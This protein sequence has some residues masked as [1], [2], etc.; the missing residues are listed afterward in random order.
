[1]GANLADH[2]G[3]DLPSGWRGRGDGGPI[4][5]SIA[6]FRSAAEPGTDAPD[7]MFWV[8]DPDAEDPAFYLDP[9]LLRPSPADR[10]G[11]GLPIRPMPP[12]IELPG[13]R[14]PVDVDRLVEGYRRG[15]EL[16]R[17]PEIRRLC[18]E[19]PPPVRE[20][21]PA[22]PARHGERVLDPP[23]GGDLRDGTLAGQRCGR[24]RPGRVHGVDGLAVVDASIIPEPPS[25][26]P[27]IITIMSRSISR[28]G[29]RRPS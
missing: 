21:T 18:P 8:S 9:V 6:T 16:A 19:P 25:G 15:L 13:L 3:V 4:L 27:H 23:R 12:R 5:H 1:M 24:R 2:P 28:R 26:F 10:S 22:A 29:W 14:E 11:C 20:T 17:R 7:L